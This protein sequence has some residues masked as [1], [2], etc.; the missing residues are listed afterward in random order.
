MR[1]DPMENFN[2]CARCYAANKGKSRTA[3]VRQLLIRIYV[4][5]LDNTQAAKLIGYT[6]T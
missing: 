6:D 5:A 2:H 3:A 1:Q 4:W